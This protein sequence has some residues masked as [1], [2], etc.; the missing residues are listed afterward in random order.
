MAKPMKTLPLE[1]LAA[2]IREAFGGTIL[3]EMRGSR[4]HLKVGP[5]AAW[6]DAT[7]CLVGESFD[8]IGSLEVGVDEDGI[9]AAATRTAVEA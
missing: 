7:G 2:S 8:G 6:F 5:K 9:A 3:A 1:R 4:V